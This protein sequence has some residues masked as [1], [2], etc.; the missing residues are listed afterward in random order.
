MIRSDAMREFRR[1]FLHALRNQL[2]AG[3]PLNTEAA[4]Q[5]ATLRTK[6]AF[7]LDARYTNLTSEEK[8]E[9]WEEVLAGCIDLQ[10]MLTYFPVDFNLVP[11]DKK[12][13]LEEHILSLEKNE[14]DN[15]HKWTAIMRE[16]SDS[17]PLKG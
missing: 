7:M 3:E 10:I 14:L 11:K 15:E 2:A 5:R 13:S 16:A 12:I 4:A 1:E 8:Q 6:S 9:D 17:L